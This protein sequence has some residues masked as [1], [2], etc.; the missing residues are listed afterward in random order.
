[1]QSLT[2]APTVHAPSISSSA[3]LAELAISVWTGRKLDKH[4][5]ATIEA[6]NSAESGTASVRKRLLGKCA[7]LDD[8]NKYVANLRNQTHYRL[9]LPWSDS[10]LRLLPTAMYFAYHKEMTYHQQEFYRMVDE[11]LD[12][13]DNEVI[14]AQLRLGD[15]FN[16]DEYPT[17]DML[18][19][20]FAFH[21]NYSPV[22]DVG[23][24]RVDI[25]NEQ[26]ETLRASYA[27]YY[28]RQLT[29]AMG[30]LWTQLHEKL[31]VLVR[32]LDYT[33]VVGEDGQ[34]STRV[35][36]VYESVFDRVRELIDMLDTC[37]VTQD[38]Q[39]YRAKRELDNILGGISVEALKGESAF[40]DETREQLA[41]V[42]K[43]LPSLDW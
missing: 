13:Y 31:S 9:S 22:P 7:E 16:P 33:P 23:D 10:G 17:R 1:M 43:T 4:A 36:R 11:F 24:F 18:A 28:E 41:A 34:H 29:A 5:S 21:I 30:D 40:R 2:T 19:R 14:Q 25:G 3:M 32:Q 35:N 38:E 12:A 39:M 42:I 27:D 15:M 26:A 37:N 20:K 8:L 6:V